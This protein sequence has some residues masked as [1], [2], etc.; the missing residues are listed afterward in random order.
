MSDIPLFPLNV[1]LM[2]GAPMPLHIFEERYKQM[3]DECMERQSEFGMVLAD[4]S[5]TRRVGCTA[6]IVDL[7]ERYEDGRML[8]LVEGSRRFRL[9]NILTGKPYYIG[10]IE[11]LEEEP[12]EEVNTLAEECIALLERV[13]EAATEGSVGIEI[14]PPYRNLSFAIAGR[15]EFDLETRQQI[16]ELTSEGERLVKVRDLL[17]AAA[18]RLEREREAREKA[19]KNGHLRGDWRPG[20]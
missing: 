4:E 19:E 1:V 18:E 6:R 15:V 12:E 9:N 14:E 10:E 11:Y 8:I 3:V 20:S 2:P 13:V 17:S 16:L 7:V 5:G